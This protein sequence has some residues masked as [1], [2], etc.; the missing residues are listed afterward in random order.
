MSSTNRPSL[1]HLITKN[2]LVAHSVDNQYQFFSMFKKAKVIKYIHIHIILAKNYLFQFFFRTKRLFGNN[3][4][5]DIFNFEFSGVQIFLFVYLGT[6]C[7][8]FSIPM[9][10]F[11]QCFYLSIIG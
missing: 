2:I 11:H 7:I 9:T 8:F 1:R 6:E 5:K 10:L 4:T 3:I